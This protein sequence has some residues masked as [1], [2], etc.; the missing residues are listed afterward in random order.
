[1]SF[2]QLLVRNR[3]RSA[4]ATIRQ[5]G[6]KYQMVS[7]NRVDGQLKNP[8]RRRRGAAITSSAAIVPLHVVSAKV[9]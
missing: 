6:F 8:V 7:K 4:H 2:V 5:V 1:M 9:E 3:S